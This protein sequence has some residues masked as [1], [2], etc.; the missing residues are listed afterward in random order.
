MSVSAWDE[1]DDFATGLN[2]MGGGDW[3][4]GAMA[5]Y[6]RVDLAARDFVRGHSDLAMSHVAAYFKSY[7]R[8][9]NDVAALTDAPGVKPIIHDDITTRMCAA[10]QAF[11]LIFRRSTR[12]SE[13]NTV[14]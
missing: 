13:A 7:Q 11:P 9:V 12:V 6:G 4:H 1:G 10:S 2:M 5:L 8:A 14:V 3:R